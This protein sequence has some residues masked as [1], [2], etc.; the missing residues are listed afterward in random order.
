MAASA[1][2]N[3]VRLRIALPTLEGPGGGSGSAGRSIP[4][5]ALAIGLVQPKR[6]PVESRRAE[7]GPAV[8]RWEHV[9]PR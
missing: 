1:S 8:E 7:K 4:N 6:A 5:V 2:S 9:T 3:G